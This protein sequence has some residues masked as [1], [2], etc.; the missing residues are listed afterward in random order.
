V[1]VRSFCRSRSGRDLGGV[2]VA[3]LG[4]G[5]ALV[6]ANTSEVV[7]EGFHG[8]LHAVDPIV[9]MDALAL[10]GTLLGG[11]GVYAF[12]RWRDLVREIQRRK[13]VEADLVGA[14][15][16]V[17]ICGFCRHLRN[18][19]GEWRP[20]EDY[21]RENTDADLSHGLCPAC[22]RTHWLG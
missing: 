12:R 2:A 16:L 21:V 5:F 1:S 11:V 6:A 15:R 17:H 22:A 10:S 13:A 9:L 4:V 7:V 19:D 20:L 18:P 3:M 14:R 8:W